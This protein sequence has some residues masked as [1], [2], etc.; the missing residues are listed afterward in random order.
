MNALIR[1][2]LDGMMVVEIAA[3]GDPERLKLS[4]RH[5]GRG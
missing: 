2:V 1:Q 5:A 3:A 4:R